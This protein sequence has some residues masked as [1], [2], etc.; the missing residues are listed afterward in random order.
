MALVH[1]FATLS[2]NR[3]SNDSCA[4]GRS[5]FD[6]IYGP[7]AIVVE[8]HKLGHAYRTLGFAVPVQFVRCET[9]SGVQVREQVLKLAAG[10]TDPGL[11]GF[12]RR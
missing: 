12:S 7:S 6:G 3:L 8:P 4:R 5:S 10:P 11:G 9:L 1:T 2:K